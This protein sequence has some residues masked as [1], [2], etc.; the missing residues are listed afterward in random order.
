MPTEFDPVARHAARRPRAL[1]VALP[2]GLAIASVAALWVVTGIPPV[3]EAV[4]PPKPTTAIALPGVEVAAAPVA[5][6]CADQ[7]VIDA[8]AAGDDE[9][10]IAAFGGGAPFRDSVVKGTAP[11]ISL[12]EPARLWVVVNKVHALSPV[13]YAPASLQAANVTT[14]TTSRQMRSD[15]AAALDAMAQTLD[16]EG[17]GELGIN[18][19]YRSY[20]LQVATYAS[21]VESK[22]Q[23]GADAVSARPGFSEHQTGLAIDVVACTPRCGS[24]EAFG[25]TEQ[26]AWVSANAWRFGFVVRYEDGATGMTGYTA[27]PWHLRYIGPQL[28]AAYHDGGYHTLEEFFGLPPAPDYTH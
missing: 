18:N 21:H 28:A 19:G 2:I 20:T 22:G 1:R 12:A 23:G 16:S 10:V 24:I 8:L 9:R 6:P 5:D 15:A 14:T 11:C 13:D 17:P 27:E 26:S 7:G 3:E 25:R 4:E